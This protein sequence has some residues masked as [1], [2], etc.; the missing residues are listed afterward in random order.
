MKTVKFFVFFG[1]I[2]GILLGIYLI[3]NLG[4]E[5][6]IG[7]T[8]I[9]LPYYIIYGVGSLISI[10]AAIFV[11]KKFSGKLIGIW[12]IATAVIA[13]V[14]SCFYNWNALSKLFLKVLPLEAIVGFLFCFVIVI[15]S[16]FLS[17]VLFSKDGKN[18]SKN[19]PT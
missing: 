15:F 4:L 11:A 18:N 2:T 17:K 12:G 1:S 19:S 9:P 7:L 16:G 3:L 10:L 5:I 8:Y 14:S 13:I 6:L